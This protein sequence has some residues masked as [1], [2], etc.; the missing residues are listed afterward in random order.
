MAVVTLRSRREIMRLAGGFAASAL[1]GVRGATAESRATDRTVSLYSVN[2]GEH[3]RA[4]YFAKWLLGDERTAADIMELN[5]EKEQ[6]GGAPP[7]TG[8]R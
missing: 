1:L 7:P 6:S 8:G 5:N 4:E 2:T 3:L